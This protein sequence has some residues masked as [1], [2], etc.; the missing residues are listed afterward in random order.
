MAKAKGKSSKDE[1]RSRSKSGSVQSRES[2][3]TRTKKVV[4]QGKGL[5]EDQPGGRG[6]EVRADAAALARS[7]AQVAAVGA[8]QAR[9]RGAAPP[10]PVPIATFNI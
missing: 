2:E 5:A 6:A 3:V 9:D 10:M 7:I 1:A 4:A 8:S